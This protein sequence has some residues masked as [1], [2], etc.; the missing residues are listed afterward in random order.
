MVLKSD[1]EKVKTLLSETIRLLCKNGLHFKSEFSVEALVGITLDRDQ[2]FFLS[3]KETVKT[4]IRPPKPDP[5]KP[6]PPRESRQ[7]ESRQSLGRDIKGEPGRSPACQRK[8]PAETTPNDGSTDLPS[9]SLG[10]MQE[11]EQSFWSSVTGDNDTNTN[12]DPKKK[13][14]LNTNDDDSNSTAVIT[15]K[16]EPGSDSEEDDGGGGDDAAGDSSQI[17]MS[18]SFTYGT[19]VTSAQTMMAGLPPGNMPGTMPGTWDHLP[20]FSMAGPSGLSTGTPPG[21]S[22]D[23]QQQVCMNCRS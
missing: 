16:G 10:D 18:S 22:P 8:R 7:S 15:I 19:P 23:A 3:I 4:D 6:P 11:G 1:K 12:H 17:D 14:R 13:Q 2:E 21:V 20:Q 9:L 5:P